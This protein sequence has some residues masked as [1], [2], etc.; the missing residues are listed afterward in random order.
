M[1]EDQVRAEVTRVVAGLLGMRAETL[2]PQ[3]PLALYG[4]DSLS[5]VE[6]VAAF[7]NAFERQLPEWLL[8][9]HP[10]LDTLTRALA[11]GP[12]DRP[13]VPPAILAD[14]RLPDDIRPPAGA[15][16]DPPKHVLLTG[17]TGFLGAYLLRAL[18]T[19]T[20]AVVH[21]LVRAADGRGLA[22]IRRNL[23]QYG[24][25][26][27]E[28]ADRIHAVSGDLSRPQLGLASPDYA[29]LCKRV[30][31]V[32]H[33]AADVN[34]ALPYVA[35]RDANV[36]ATREL[37][38]LACTARPKVFH[39]V[40]SL[41][42]CYAVGGPASVGE[43][44][45]M[46]PSVQ[47]LPL[48]Y[49]QSKCVAESLVRQA[50]ARGLAARIYRPSLITGDST[51]GASNLDDLVAALL[52]GCIQMGA[53]PDLDWTF[54]APPVDHVVNA[55]MRLTDPAEG[56]LR[57]FNISNRRS[58]H[59]RECVLWANVRGYPIALV[60]YQDWRTQLE[61]DAASPDHA[62][63]RLR[64]FF[65]RP[66]LGG[67]TIA[68]LYQDESRSAVDCRQTQR[69]EAAAGLDCA[70][71]DAELLDR[72][73]ANYIA[74]GFLPTPPQPRQPPRSVKRLS[75]AHE[76]PAFFD[77][78]FQRRFQDGSIRVSDVALVSRGSEHSVISELT[79]WQCGRPTGL[80]HYRVTIERQR[81]SETLDV[82]V[83]AKPTDDDVLDVGETL[84]TLCHPALG[85]EIHAHRDRIGIRGGH[86]RE[87]AIYEEAQRNDRLRPYLPGCFGTWR[88][89]EG[90]QWGMAIE[91]LNGLA[92]MDASD[93]PNAWSPAHIEAAV[94]GL[95]ELHAVWHEREAELRSQPWIGH[96]RSRQ[97]VVEMTPLWQALAD[98]AAPFFAA[99]A[100]PAIGPTHR[101][102]VDSIGEWWQPLD[103]SPPTL[104]HNDFNPRNVSLRHEGRGFRLCAYDWELATVGAPPRD[105]A[106]FLC[107][108]LP[109]D[110]RADEAERYVELHRHA[111]A[112]ATGRAI[113]AEE[114]R[115][116]FRSALA[117]FLIDRLAF[118]AMIHRVRRQRFLPRVVRTWWR[119][120]H[121]IK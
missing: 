21:C 23:E 117:D 44:D 7:E 13:Y 41:S 38:R 88:D 82:M 93:D 48:G 54:D 18:L 91:H 97:S 56:G 12:Q 39:F 83:K 73:F 90:G 85:R 60:P 98:H 2:D 113:D 74:R 16:I 62:L 24:L 119:L 65:L 17:A 27:A 72:Y 40:S 121:V 75:A 34:W 80:F 114:W 30:D 109:P 11:A 79:A 29:C 3:T 53:A 35:L 81:T 86:V 25:W 22:R 28:T 84:A 67:A 15:P 33:A 101:A 87:L 8:V 70:R 69:A 106:E 51:S 76:A 37:L 68:E 112:N 94:V 66:V 110:V 103:S 61:R 26:Y 96:V 107:F 64:S 49:A 89:D 59:W 14:S 78:L 116:V 92:L 57:T 31:A 120:H 71:L 111:L 63:H 77:R 45:D 32:Y 19:Q 104:I 95:A 55:I 36:I 46:L 50:S 108:V 118:Y 43:D 99:W 9:E 115:A 5:S 10:D 47:R 42:V 100:D 1:R 20:N 52:K 4:L 6:L 102:L 105:L 58:R